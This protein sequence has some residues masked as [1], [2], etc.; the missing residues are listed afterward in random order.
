[1]NNDLVFCPL[2]NKDIANPL[3]LSITYAAEGRISQADIPET[4]NWEMAK[5]ICA[6]CGNAYWNKNN[7]EAPVLPEEEDV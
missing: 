1:M 4:I 5:D 2:L 3:C 7:L 6:D